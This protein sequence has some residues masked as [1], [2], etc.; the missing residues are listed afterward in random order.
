MDYSLG[1]FHAFGRAIVRLENE[2]L[3]GLMMATRVGVN[4]D[5]KAYGKMV[6]A[7]SGG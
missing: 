4:G 3:R 5:E 2:R 7:L 6:K 1:Q